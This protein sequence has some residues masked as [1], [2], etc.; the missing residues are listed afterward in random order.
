M[1]VPA[2][3]QAPV[4]FECPR[5]GTTVEYTDGGRTVWGGVDPT[6]PVVCLA[7]QG[8][9]DR[10]LLYAFWRLPFTHHGSEAAT[11]TGLGQLWPA[12]A[13]RTVTYDLFLQRQGGGDDP[14]RE[15][16]RVI[17]IEPITVRAGT[18]NALVIER[19]QDGRG[20]NVFRGTW[21]RWIDLDS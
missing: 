10:R 12:A 20:G 14:Y 19:V 1:V 5:A 15:T 6:D 21:R 8:N 4:A 7:R 2:H 3:S 9:N 18:Y 11:R 16:W 13:G 17:G